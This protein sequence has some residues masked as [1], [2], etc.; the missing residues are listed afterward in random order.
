MGLK[1]NTL[2]ELPSNIDRSYYLYILDYYNWD[3]PIGNTLRDNFDKIAEF[4]ANNN[5]IVIQ[6]IKE[7][8]FYSELLSFDAVNGLPPNE[9]LPALM[10][11]TIHSKYFLDANDKILKG[12]KIPDDKLIFIKIGSICKKPIDVIKLIEKIFSDIKDKK[13]IEDFSIKK[14]LKSGKDNAI[15]DA[16]ILEPNNEGEIFNYNYIDNFFRQDEVLLNLKKKINTLQIQTKREIENGIKEFQ[17]GNYVSSVRI[18]FPTIEEITNQKLVNN[19]EDPSDYSKYRGLH[20]KLSFL[21]RIG[22]I[23]SDLVQTIKIT[24]ERNTVLHGSYNPIKQEL[25]LPLCYT[26]MTFL[27]EMID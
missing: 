14:E 26:S 10:I 22:K 16:L 18:L 24:T 1:I 20:D 25:A 21:Q 17:K 19:G 12:V 23:S 15:N 3:E 5:S 13:E 2:A 11:T 6:G 27:T 4:A 8:H 9:L 7:S